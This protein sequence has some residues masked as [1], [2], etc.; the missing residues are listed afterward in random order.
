MSETRYLTASEIEGWAHEA[1]VGN[2]VPRPIMR[3]LCRTAMTLYLQRESLAKLAAES[4]QFNN[5]INE[6]EAQALRDAVLSGP[7]DIYCTEAR[8]YV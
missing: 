6:W 4:P 8:K 7:R 1:E 5:P 2:Y 3:A